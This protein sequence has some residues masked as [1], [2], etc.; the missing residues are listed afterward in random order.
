MDPSTAALGAPEVAAAPR[1]WPGWALLAWI[2]ACHGAGLLGA[3]ATDPSLYRELV[4]PTWAPPGWLFGPVWTALYTMMGVAGWLVWR[5]RPTPA[6]RTAL[7][8]FAAQL[9]L[10]ALW[11][12]V[13]F[14]LEAVGA[15][16]FVIVALL[17]AIVATIL[18]A[19]PVSRVAAGLLAPY[20][21]WVGFATALNASLWYLN[22]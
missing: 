9:G 8:M 17:A 20:L 12:P 1:R 13:F 2:A 16:L 19:R 3:L 21:A 22:L 14:G 7:T 6:R 5:A 11:T 10:N 18:A 4:R 15:A